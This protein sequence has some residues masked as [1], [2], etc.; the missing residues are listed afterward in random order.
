MQLVLGAGMLKKRIEV[1]MIPQ[2]NAFQQL[3]QQG[4]PGP[5]QVDA[6]AV[7]I[8]ASWLGWAVQFFSHL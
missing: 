6:A 4:F 8:R 2:R 7:G 3:H 1:S 5:S